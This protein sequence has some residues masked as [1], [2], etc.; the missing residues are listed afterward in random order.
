VGM[1]AAPLPSQEHDKRS[2]DPV[3]LIGLIALLGAF[4]A[5][6]AILTWRLP[7][8]GNV[9]TAFKAAAYGA[10][11]AFEW[12]LAGYAAWRLPQLGLS[13]RNVINIPR[14]VKR[15]LL[16][17]LVACGFWVIVAAVAVGLQFLLQ[18]GHPRFLILIPENRT[19]IALWC[20]LSLTAGFC[21][22]LVF[23]GY[24]QQT[25]KR[26]WNVGWA[27]AAQAIFFGLVHIYQGF[28][29][30]VPILVLGL[31][32]GCVAYWRRSLWPGMLV[33]MWTDIAGVIFR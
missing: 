10:V 5:V 11:F 3:G 28:K 14:T 16:D 23:R 15:W 18:P 20:V 26:Y 17:V 19:E 12:I 24:L 27:I 31:M 21:E 25:L 22:E 9:S 30:V 32:F 33:H 6:S 2:N 13:A 8:S 29:S 4:T 7:S 1:N